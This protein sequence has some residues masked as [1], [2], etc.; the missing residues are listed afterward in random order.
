MLAIVLFASCRSWGQDAKMYNQG[1]ISE[2]LH[3][4]MI[5]DNRTIGVYLTVCQQNELSPSAWAS[6]LNK[7]FSAYGFPVKIILDESPPKGTGAVARI[8]VAAKAYQGNLSSG[9]IGLS[10]LFTEHQKVFSELLELYKKANPDLFT[11]RR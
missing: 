6:T 8:Y 1:P 10:Y 5:P 2:A 7:Y 3:A 4:S 11:D 9:D